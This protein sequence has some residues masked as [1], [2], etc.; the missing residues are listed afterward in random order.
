MARKRITTDDGE[1]RILPATIYPEGT[2]KRAAPK[3]Q[4][5]TTRKGKIVTSFTID[6]ELHTWVRT[7]LM[8]YLNIYSMGGALEHVLHRYREQLRENRE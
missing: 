2:R 4:R 1:E 7:E 6:V 3:V 8:P 5:Y